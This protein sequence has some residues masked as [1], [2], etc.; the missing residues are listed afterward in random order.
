MKQY[1]F[2]FILHPGTLGVTETA[3]KD[4]R[5]ELSRRVDHSIAILLVPEVR[6]SIED[7]YGIAIVDQTVN[8]IHLIGDGFTGN[9]SGTGGAGH[10]AARAMFSIMGVRPLQ[11]APEEGIFFSEDLSMY[12][13]FHKHIQEMIK[14]EMLDFSVPS[15]NKPQYIDHITANLLPAI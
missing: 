11:L 5:D 7:G 9:G 14:D 13:F 2:Q 1:Q 12:T 10:R 3:L 8:E 4:L 15:M 6:S